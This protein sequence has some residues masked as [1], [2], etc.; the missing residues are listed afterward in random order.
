MIVLDASVLIAYLDEGDGHHADAEA[1]LEAAVDDDLGINPLTLAEVLVGPVR[2]DR[3][4]PVQETLRD[5]EVHEV[6]F[7]GDAAVRLARLRA[8]TGLK[9]PDCCVVLAAEIADATVGTFD[10]QL[11]RVTEERKAPHH[12]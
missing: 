4:G 10:R 7:P 2:H 9:M 3:L 8:E 11:S 5:L 6:P 1:M 12:L